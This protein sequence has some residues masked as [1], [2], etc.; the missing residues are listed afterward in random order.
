MK[1]NI[2]KI[3]LIV[4]SFVI[5]IHSSMAAPKYTEYGKIVF[6]GTGWND[7][8]LLVS[9]NAPFIDLGCTSKDGYVASKTVNAGYNGHKS[10]LLAAFMSGTKV[11]LVLDGCH[12]HGRPKIIGVQMYKP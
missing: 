11:K 12:P 9:L 8:A 5:V 10:A 6:Y 1:I 3:I 4:A 7:E 2:P